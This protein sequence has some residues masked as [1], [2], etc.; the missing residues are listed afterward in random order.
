MIWSSRKT[1]SVFVVGVIVLIALNLATFIIAY[2][3]TYTPSPGISNGPILAKDFSAYYIGAWKLWNNPS[4]IYNISSIASGQPQILPHPEG[5]KYLP[6]F[7]VITSPLLLLNYQDALLTFDI[8]QFLLLPFIAFFIYRLMSNKPLAVTLIVLSI[9]LLLPFPTAKWGFSP[10]YYWQWGEGQAKVVLLF[11]L[12]LSF[13]LGNRGKT[14]L[15]GVVFAF[16]FFDPR[17]GLLA[18]PLFLL[19]NRKN[20][21]VAAASAAVAL[22]LSNLILLYPGMGIGFLDM[23][24]SSGVPTPIYYYSYIPLFTLLALIAVYFKEIVAF[25][26]YKHVLVKNKKSTTS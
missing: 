9:A 11:L 17:F 4:Q 5:Y 18:L 14:V 10:S 7:L 13:Y 19:F 2:P 21:K 22:G 6:S 1:K 24:F 15:S 23:V 16:G 26:D 12:T 25:F 3:E 20:L 8:L